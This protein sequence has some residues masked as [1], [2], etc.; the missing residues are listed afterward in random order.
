MMR[1][2]YLLLAGMALA[3]VLPLVAQDPADPAEPKIVIEPSSTKLSL[4]KAELTV[5]PLECKAPGLCGTY[6]IKVTP[7]TFKNDFGKLTLTMSDLIVGKMKAGEPVEFTG[8]A[9][10]E[11]D[12]KT[13][14]IKGTTTP[15]AKETG[16]VNFVVTSEDGDL[17]FNSSYH[18]VR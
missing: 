12:G 7:F 14:A 18:L 9:T 15:N 3:G 8:M 6:T 5:S 2:F 4:A 10:S 16:L 11:R 17:V 1:R 13:K